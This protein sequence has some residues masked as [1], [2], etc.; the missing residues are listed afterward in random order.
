MGVSSSLEDKEAS[1]RLGVVQLL[2]RLNQTWAVVSKRVI[3][4][5]V[6]ER[7]KKPSQSGAREKS[8]ESKHR[9]HAV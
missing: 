5:G 8:S 3:H 7:S 1:F 2:R 9:G 4:G 6:L